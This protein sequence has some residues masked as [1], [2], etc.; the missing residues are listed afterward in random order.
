MKVHIP[1]A[2]RRWTEG[3]PEIEIGFEQTRTAAEVLEALALRYPGVRDRIMDE[4]GNLRRHVNIF[5]D[6]ENARLGGGL[7]AAVRPDSEL[8]I[9]PAL[10]GGAP[11]HP[12]AG[13]NAMNTDIEQRTLRI[14]RV[15]DAPRELV[16]K[17]WTDPEHISQWWGPKGFATTVLKLDLRPGGAY[18]FHMRSTEG[19]EHWS[20]GTFLEIA[21][22]ARLVMAGCW[23]DAHGNPV[24]PESVLT[25]TFAERDGKTVLSLHQVLES[26]AARDSHRGGWNSSFDRLESYLSAA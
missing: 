4:Q 21:P 20:Q 9:H 22:P 3:S 17:A 1:A 14:E 13:G 25:V 5:I 23:A 10:S 12:F 18:R 11:P 15:F 24:S 8:W 7:N 6:G 16:F 2:L 19:A 26:V